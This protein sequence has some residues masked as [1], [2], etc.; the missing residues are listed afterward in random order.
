MGCVCTPLITRDIHLREKGNG[1]ECSVFWFNTISV[2]YCCHFANVLYS[3]IYLLIGEKG[4]DN[5]IGTALYL[6]PGKPG[7]KSHSWQK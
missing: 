4:V 1:R 5:I 3:C 6:K 7:L 2:S